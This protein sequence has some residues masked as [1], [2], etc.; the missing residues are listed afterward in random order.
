MGE[1]MDNIRY[2]RDMEGHN[3]FL[4]QVY[5][6]LPNNSRHKIISSLRPNPPG[7]CYR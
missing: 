4:A 2:P 6:V 7:R 1:A 3:D 5:E